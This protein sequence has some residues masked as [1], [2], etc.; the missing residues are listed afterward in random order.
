MIRSLKREARVLHERLDERFHFNNIIGTQRLLDA[1][2]ATGRKG[3]SISR[4][5]GLGEMNAEQLWET[6]LDPENRILLQVKVEDAE[7]AG[8]IDGT[9]TAY[10]YSGEVN[11]APSVGSGVGEA[12]LVTTGSVAAAWLPGDTPP[13]DALI[14]GSIDEERN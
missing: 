2:L 11:S 4:Y 10:P 5:K 12:V 8:T 6:T 3:L 7:I 9:L 1:V 14:I 13:I